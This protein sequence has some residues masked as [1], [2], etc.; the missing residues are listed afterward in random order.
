M[1]IYEAAREAVAIGGYITRPKQRENIKLTNT[2]E[3][4]I[5]IIGNDGLVGVRWQPTEEELL[6]DDWRVINRGDTGKETMN[7]CEAL[8]KAVAT[9]KYITR[10]GMCGKKIKAVDG[11]NIVFDDDGNRLPPAYGWQPSA[12]DLTANDWQIEN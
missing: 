5:G 9:G 7:I 11:M 10:P 1:N 3:K 6:A 12:D 2:D 8:K 4:C